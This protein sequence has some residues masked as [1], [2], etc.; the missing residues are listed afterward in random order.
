LENKHVEIGR[1]GAAEVPRDCSVRAVWGVA[2]QWRFLYVRG[3][4]GRVAAQNRVHLH[5][6]TTKKH[7]L[8]N[9]GLQVFCA[10]ATPLTQNAAIVTL[11]K[12]VFIPPS[13][14]LAASHRR[15]ELLRTPLDAST[16]VR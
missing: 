16:Y 3:T 11:F 2:A 6:I 10:D 8:R 13:V 4:I 14:F 9:V 15:S 7:C 5:L 12:V 1:A